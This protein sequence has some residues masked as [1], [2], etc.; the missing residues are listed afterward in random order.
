MPEQEQP[1]ICYVISDSVGETAELVV[2]AA[3]SQFNSHNCELKR[4]PY[5]SDAGTIEEVVR[6]A[7]KFKSIVAYTL[8]DPTLRAHMKELSQRY[9]IEAV[10]IMGPMLNSFQNVV[11][12]EPKLEPGLV[13][14]LDESYFK[15]VDAIEFAVKYDDGKDPRG[16]LK[17]DVT[18]I[19]V[20]RTSKTPLSMYLANKRLKVANLPLVPEVKPPQEL[21]E[22]PSNKV[23]GLIISPYKLNEI[24]K[25]RLKTLGLKSQA[26][27]ANM[28]RI[29]TEL[30]YAEEIMKK[31]GCPTIDVSNR[32]VEETAQKILDMTR[33][34]NF[35]GEEQ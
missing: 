5:V 21:Y 20:S 25:E 11:G 28:E 30:D 27:Y 22:V 7:V 9:Q 8:V 26:N 24:R 17:S 12:K 19:G 6:E 34:G 1:P 15:R 29:M 31:V 23:I 14:K 33:G 35:D 3:T 18:L 4:I 16:L 13:R 10:D 2:K 32:A